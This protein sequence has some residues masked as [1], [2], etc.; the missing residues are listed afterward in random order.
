MRLLRL[1]QLTLPHMVARRSGQIAVVSSAAGKVG[2]PPRTG[3]CAAKHACVGFFDALRAEVE[4]AY[5]VDVSVILPGSVKTAV[6]V[7]AL[8]GKGAANGRSD[9]NIEGGM[10]ADAAAEAIL[11][12]LAAKTREIVVAEGMELNAIRMRAAD[13]ETLFAFAAKE[14]AR[15][16]ALREQTGSDFAPENSR[17]NS[18][19]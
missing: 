3:Y 18:V 7:N 1:T 13:P 19:T 15:L 11:A 9:A 16:S 10:S 8:T 6:A 5:G 12:G 4:T 17:F 2:A 14:G